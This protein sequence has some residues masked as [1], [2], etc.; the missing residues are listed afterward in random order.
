[1]SDVLVPGDRDVR[2]T[3]EEP[4]S[5]DGNKSRD[6]PDAIVIAC[7][8]HPQHGGSRTDPRLVAVSDALL[9]AE[10]ACLRFDY[11]PWDEGAGEREDVRN[12]ICWANERYDRVGVFGYSFGATLALIAAPDAA[13]DAV[14]VLAPTARLGEDLDALE[15]LERA[16][17]P[18]CVLYGE[19]DT[20]VDW[21]PIVEAATERGD[22]SVELS[23]DHFF[24]G[25]HGEIA[26]AI[27]EFFERTL[28]ESS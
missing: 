15:G 3:L 22:E 11:G 23:G 24:L 5:D 17:L 9:E 20:T 19:R 18:V 12:A 2:G 26:S 6:D 10:I 16:E 27:S 4:E 21:S 8:P 7:P 28:L 1:M 14:S 13:C 25:K